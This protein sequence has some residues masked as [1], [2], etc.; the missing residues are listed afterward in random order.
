[1]WNFLAMIAI[2]IAIS[3]VSYLLA[4]KPKTTKNQQSQDLRE[5]V[6]EAGKPIPVAFG[7]VTVMSPN[8][9]Y[10]G[11]VGKIQYEVDA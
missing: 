6:A 3:I 4:P 7:E 1:M 2:S 9:M 11:D 8:V 5:P 10:Y